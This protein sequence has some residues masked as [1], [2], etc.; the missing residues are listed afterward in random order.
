MTRF[1]NL[2]EFSYMLQS[3][4]QIPSTKWHEIFDKLYQL[5]DATPVNCYAKPSGDPPVSRHLISYYT[6]FND[7]I[8]DVLVKHGHR[9]IYKKFEGNTT[10]RVPSFDSSGNI[11]FTEQH[12][13]DLDSFL[14]IELFVKRMINGWVERNSDRVI[15][16]LSA[17][18]LYY[19]PIENYDRNEDIDETSNG[20]KTITRELAEDYDPMG[21][22]INSPISGLSASLEG[23][24][25]ERI[26][27]SS[28]TA[29]GKVT[30]TTTGGGASASDTQNGQKVKEAKVTMS[31]GQLTA[32]AESQTGADVITTE[33]VSTYDDNDLHNNRENESKGTVANNSVSSAYSQTDLY[34][35]VTITKDNPEQYK[36]TEAFENFGTNRNGRIHGNIGVTTTQQMIEQEYI[37]RNKRLVDDFISECMNEIFLQCGA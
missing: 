20:S 27:L 10:R 4:E 17:A 3:Y 30:V 14:D 24:K 31:A 9:Y 21:F 11:T 32:T 34:G 6:A 19:D 37:L 18:E 36:D 33:K 28:L 23:T 26:S 7:F 35:N 29:E 5:F 16:T 2:E 25:N 15:R 13:S 8:Y 1:L 12:V 22:S